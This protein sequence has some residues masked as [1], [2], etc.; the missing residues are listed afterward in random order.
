VQLVEAL[1]ADACVAEH[2]PG[3]R[4]VS[5]SLTAELAVQVAPEQA[6]TVVVYCSG[7]CGCGG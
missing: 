6:A 3:A 2:L 1:P 4:N 5:G 7:T